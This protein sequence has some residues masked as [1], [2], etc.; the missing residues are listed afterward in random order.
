MDT[1]ERKALEAKGYKIYDHAAD[2]VGL[3]DEEKRELD[4][5]VEKYSKTPSQRNGAAPKRAKRGTVRGK[6]QKK[7]KTKT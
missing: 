1:A 2:A 7:G 5:R 4:A 3:T 6:V